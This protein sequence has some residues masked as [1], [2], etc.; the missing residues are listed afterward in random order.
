MWLSIAAIVAIAALCC[1]YGPGLLR[2]K[3]REEP[4]EA[5]PLPVSAENVSQVRVCANGKKTA[6]L[7]LR[8]PRIPEVEWLY[9]AFK[10]SIPA[11]AR[12]LEHFV[13]KAYMYRLD[14]AGDT[15]AAD[16]FYRSISSLDPDS[17]RDD[18]EFALL[19]EEAN[20]DLPLDD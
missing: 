16:E 3:N 6:K 18:I 9:T 7:I 14:Q 15:D 2:S 4:T 8:A 17:V 5:A 1:F 11:D 10:A 12:F 20:L 19:V 13:Q